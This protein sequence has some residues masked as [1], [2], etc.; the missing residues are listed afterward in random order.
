[1]VV[2]F[3][4]AVSVFLVGLVRAA[5]VELSTSDWVLYTGCVA[6]EVPVATIIPVAT[7]L[8]VA[9]LSRLGV[10]D[11]PVWLS[12]HPLEA[13]SGR[14]VDDHRVK[15]GNAMPRPVAF[16][17]PKAKSLGQCPFFLLFP[18]SFPSSSPRWE[19]SFPLFSNIWSLVERP[20]AHVRSGSIGDERGGGDRGFEKAHLWCV[21][22]TLGCNILAVCL[23]TD[24]ATA[25]RIAT[26]EEASPG[27]DVTLLWHNR[28]S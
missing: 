18:F 6:T 19:A 23:P 28:P 25:V 16:W 9:F 20:A 11:R 2:V 12:R 24:V 22:A 4:L 3:R 21:V 17:G 5:L 27:S 1:S 26:S 13:C 10:A 8:C 14:G 15:S 7:P